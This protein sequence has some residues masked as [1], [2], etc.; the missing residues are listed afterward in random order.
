MP[1]V[2]AR[3]CVR[4]DCP[5]FLP[6]QHLQIL[7]QTQ[8]ATTEHPDGLFGVLHAN[9]LKYSP[10]IWPAPSANLGELLLHNNSMQATNHAEYHAMT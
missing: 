9:S 1:T 4:C 10:P 6:A 8:G 5:D 7:G 2:N 3:S